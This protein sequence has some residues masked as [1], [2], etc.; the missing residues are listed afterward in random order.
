M[1]CAPGGLDI[2][3]IRGWIL[4]IAI[5]SISSTGCGSTP[6]KVTGRVTCDGNPVKGT[7]LFSPFGEGEK[8]T[9]QA[10]TA[11][12]KEDGSY[13]IVLKTIGKHRVVVS[14]SDI[15]YPAPP[16]KEYPCDLTPMERELNVGNNVINIELPHRAK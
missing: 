10:E 5:V 2:V 4:G 8:N 6:T 16:G 3:M 1:L 15:V 7:I 14:P 12:L 13:E 11:T 9:G